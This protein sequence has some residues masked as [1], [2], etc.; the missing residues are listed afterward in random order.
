MSKNLHDRNL[1]ESYKE[2]TNFFYHNER[3][4]Q[5]KISNIPNVLCIYVGKIEDFMKIARDLNIEAVKNNPNDHA[6][7]IVFGRVKLI[8]YCTKHDLP[9][10]EEP[11]KML[12]QLEKE[13]G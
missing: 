9:V 10:K 5:G 8:F 4:L 7:Q 11:Y 13:Q 2:L 6:I 3:Y 12:S 1:Y